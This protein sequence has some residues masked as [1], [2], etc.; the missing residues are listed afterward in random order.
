MMGIKRG[1]GISMVLALGLALVAS[2]A[3]S[4]VDILGLA[5]TLGIFGGIVYVCLAAY[6]VAPRD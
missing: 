1:I 3:I 5:W 4:M 2:C 6:L